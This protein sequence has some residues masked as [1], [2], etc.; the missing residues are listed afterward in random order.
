MDNGF[1]ETSENE[2][3]YVDASFF[4]DVFDRFF[5]N[6]RE[7][8]CI[9]FLQILLKIH[10]KDEN[11]EQREYDEQKD[12]LIF[13]EPPLKKLIEDFKLAQLRDPHTRRVAISLLIP[14]LREKDA[15]I[16]AI[17]TEIL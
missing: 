6:V 12:L 14:L 2:N 7:R 13:S 17:V 1:V 4:K 10:Q 16:R 9:Y 15:T 11:E 8:Y 3:I 5:S